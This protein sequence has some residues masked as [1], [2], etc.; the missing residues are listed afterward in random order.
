MRYFVES[1]LSDGIVEQPFPRVFPGAAIHWAF[2]VSCEAGTFQF[3]ISDPFEE[4]VQ[5]MNVPASN[6][7]V[8]ESSGR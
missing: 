6:L 4:H 5:L 7:N 3:F 1:P 2:A 8:R